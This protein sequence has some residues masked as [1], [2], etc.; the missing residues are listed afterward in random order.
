MS[1]NRYRGWDVSGEDDVMRK[2]Q[3][4]QL[5][6]KQI[7]DILYPAGKY[8][9]LKIKAAA[10]QIDDNKRTTEDMKYRRGYENIWLEWDD[11]SKTTYVSTGDAYWLYFIE[12]SGSKGVSSSKKFRLNRQASRKNRGFRANPFMKPTYEANRAAIQRLIAI[13]AKRVLGL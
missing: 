8:L 13:Q 11:R 1:S 5:T 2:L 4:L 6:E 7:K 12:Q 3:G 10:K 9:Q